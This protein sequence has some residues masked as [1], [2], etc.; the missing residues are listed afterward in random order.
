MSADNWDS[1]PRCLKRAL[2]VYGKQADAVATLYGKVSVEEFDAARKGL[3]VPQREDFVTFR[4][5]YE[6]SGAASG[7][8]T[9]TY[10]GTCTVCRLA[11]SF[12]HS[13]GIPGVGD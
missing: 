11:L 6:T 2:H 10:S 4:E 3:V 1:C 5:D 12:E 9:V 8:V 7:I 13:E